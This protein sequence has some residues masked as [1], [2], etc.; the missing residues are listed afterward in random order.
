[1]QY[2]IVCKILQDPALSIVAKI[3]YTGARKQGQ[4]YSH[5]NK[6]INKAKLKNLD[7]QFEPQ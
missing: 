6:L 1:M 5:H 4:A 7:S 2:S 3:H